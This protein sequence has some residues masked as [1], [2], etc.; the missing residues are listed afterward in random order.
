MIKCVNCDSED[1]DVLIGTCCRQVT[2]CSRRCQRENWTEHKKSCEQPYKV[3]P[4]D[5]KGMGLVAT[6]KIKRGERIIVEKPVLQTGSL[7]QQFQKLSVRQQCDLM[8]RVSESRGEESVQYQDQN[9]GPELSYDDYHQLSELFKTNGIQTTSDPAGH[10]AWYL[11]ISRINHSCDPGVV[12]RTLSKDNHLLK[13]VIA[14]RDI[15]EGEEVEAAYTDFLMEYKTSEERRE[16]LEKYWNFTCHCSLC[17]DPESNDQKRK[18]LKSYNESADK[19]A[20]EG[21]YGEAVQFGEK[22]LIEELN[23]PEFQTKLPSTMM[24]LYRL[25]VKSQL[26]GDDVQDHSHLVE[27]SRRLAQHVGDEELIEFVERVNQECNSW[28]GK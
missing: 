24:S 15:E 6:K 19:L 27:E 3:V 1:T 4:V 13:E 12:W 14:L 26:S 17:T 23:L 20:K 10:S 22:M 7:V 25:S 5:G 21:K 9:T 28:L 16:T 11:T 2:F 18:D 8:S